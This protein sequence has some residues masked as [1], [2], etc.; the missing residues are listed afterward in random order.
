MPGGCGFCKRIK[1]KIATMQD[2]GMSDKQV[3]DAVVRENGSQMFLAEPGAL[4]W[5][6]PFLAIAAGLALI[7]WFMRRN[8]RTPALAAGPAMPSA[9]M[10]RYNERIEKDLEKLE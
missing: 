9:D 1:T 3:I 2:A 4:G 7:F 8:T 6:T 10:D 5:L